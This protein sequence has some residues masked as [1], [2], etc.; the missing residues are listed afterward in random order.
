MALDLKE[1]RF[2][3]MLG[4]TGIVAVICTFT[5]W[6]SA[7]NINILSFEKWGGRLAFLGGWIMI[8]ATMISYDIFNSWTLRNLRP[9]IDSGLGLGGSILVL[10]GGISFL[11]GI[12]NP[13]SPT[14]GTY[15]TIALGL[16]GILSASLLYVSEG[17]LTLE[18]KRG[19]L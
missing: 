15:P 7:G 12:S 11:V 13:F 19:G 16:L 14:W 9:A 3:A 5:P 8:I 17:G 1:F 6:A 2:E 18:R 4:I 10:V